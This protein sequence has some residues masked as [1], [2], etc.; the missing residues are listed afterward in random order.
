M[1][2]LIKD[3]YK[4]GIIPS[5]EDIKKISAELRRKNEN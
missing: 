2:G 4:K 3:Y 1:L 5:E